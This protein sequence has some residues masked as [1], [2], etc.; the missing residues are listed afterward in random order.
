MQRIAKNSREN[1]K[2]KWLVTSDILLVN[3]SET[4]ILTFC[5][6][7]LPVFHNP[8]NFVQDGLFM[9]QT[10]LPESLRKDLSAFLKLWFYRVLA[11]CLNNFTYDEM[12]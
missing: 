12:P 6:L 11:R 4:E 7:P 10:W 8:I 9:L 5:L 2:S 3:R 1:D